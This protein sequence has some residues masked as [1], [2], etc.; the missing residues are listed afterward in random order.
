MNSYVKMN[1][2]PENSVFIWTCV[3]AKPSY[4]VLVFIEVCVCESLQ[5]NSKRNQSRNM[6]F[7]YFVVYE[8]S[9]DKFYI[10]HCRIKA[11]VIVGLQKIS[12]YIYIYTVR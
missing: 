5:D 4:I 3:F 10:G 1:Q 2:S 7:E 12:P 6:K 8:N 9:L 11:K